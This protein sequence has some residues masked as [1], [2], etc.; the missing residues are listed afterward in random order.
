MSLQLLWQFY[1]HTRPTC[2]LSRLVEGELADIN[3]PVT[4]EHFNGRVFLMVEYHAPHGVKSQDLDNLSIADSDDESSSD[5]SDN[6]EAKQ[7]RVQKRSAKGAVSP[8]LER[9][10][11]C[12]AF[13]MSLYD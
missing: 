9:V 2:S 1:C 8:A 5:S 11:P 4:L 12:F 3:G 13:Y 10:G 6:E 7:V